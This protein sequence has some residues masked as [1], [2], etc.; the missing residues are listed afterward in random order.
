MTHVLRNAAKRAGIARS[1]ARSTAAKLKSRSTPPARSDRTQVS[2]RRVTPFTPRGTARRSRPPRVKRGSVMRCL[3]LVAVLALCGCASQ[4]R[5]NASIASAPIV[6]GSVCVKAARRRP[7]SGS[8]HSTPSI[9]TPRASRSR[10][11]RR[12]RRRASSGRARRR[13]ALR[14]DSGGAKGLH[15]RRHSR[16][17]HRRAPGVRRHTETVWRRTPTLLDSRTSAPTARS[18]PTRPARL[19][20]SSRT[21]RRTSSVTRAILRS[22]REQP[23]PRRPQ[24]QDAGATNARRDLRRK[25][26]SLLRRRARAGKVPRP[27]RRQEPRGILGRGRS[28]LLQVHGTH[29]PNDINTSAM[30]QA[31]D[32]TLFAIIDGVF[33]GAPPLP[34]V[35]RRRRRRSGARFFAYEAPLSATAAHSTSRRSTR[36]GST[37][38]KRGQYPATGG[39]CYR[40]KRVPARPRARRREQLARDG[41]DPRVPGPMLGVLRRRERSVPHL[42][43]LPRRR[44]VARRDE[45]GRRDERVGQHPAQL[46]TVTRF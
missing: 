15:S 14:A 16:V 1:C 20:R 44:H 27:L 3:P 31:Y 42:Q 37:R 24:H 12:A 23:R 41:G 10:P 11:R 8:I 26:E 5:A 46:W 19:I 33:H 4:S 28:G 30:L 36:A 25:G 9:A 6:A 17:D 21:A 39:G 2:T 7:R 32:P 38:A 45:R 29:D 13:R 18:R 43:P 34:R 22:R 35:R 40:L